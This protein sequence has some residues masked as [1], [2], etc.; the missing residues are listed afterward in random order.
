M[1]R[2]GILN[3]GKMGSAIAVILLSKGNNVHV[4]DRSKEKLRELVAKGAIAH[5][6]PY[7][8]AKSVDVVITSITDDDVVDSVV[9]G[10]DGR[11][12]A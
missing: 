11:C 3:L 7:E 8:L 12:M 10:K 6:S 5:P 9:M 2:I 4:Y 1:A